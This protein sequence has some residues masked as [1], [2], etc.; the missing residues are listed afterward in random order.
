MAFSDIAQRIR[1]PRGLSA[2]YRSQ[3]QLL[4]FL[5]G[6]LYDD[7]HLTPFDQEYTG[8]SSGEYIRL[9]ERRPSVVSNFA[10]Q[11]VEQTIGLL[12][13]DEQFPIVRC[14]RADNADE[15]DTESEKQIQHLIEA[16]GADQV[17]ARATYLGSVG[18]AAVVVRGLPASHTAPDGQPW[19]E[20]WPG[21]QC[22]P[23]FDPRNPNALTAIATIY[24][25]TGEALKIAGYD[26]LKDD[27]QQTFWMR[28]DLDDRKEM[29][30]KPMRQ[31]RFERIGEDDKGA[32]IKWE[33]QA[34][35]A[36]RFGVVPAVWGRA[37]NAGR[38]IDGPCVFGAAVDTIV[39]LDYQLS[40]IG[41]AY[42]YTADPLLAVKRG[43]LN[44]NSYSPQ[45]S[46]PSQTQT[47]GAGNIV[48]SA[49]N[50]LDIPAGGDAKLLEI[51]GSGL[52]AALDYVRALREYALESIGGM[53]SDAATQKGAQSGRA[54]ELLYQALVIVVK[55]LRIAWGTNALLPLLSLVLRGIQTGELSVPGCVGIDPQSIAM[56]LKWPQWM[57]PTG[58]DFLSTAQGWQLLAGGSAQSPVPILDRETVTRIAATNLGFQDAETLVSEVAAQNESDAQDELQSREQSLK[59]SAQ[60]APPPPSGKNQGAK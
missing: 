10:R 13:A 34:I 1:Y 22:V 28:I 29:R 2:R 16:I 40:Q 21:Y 44:V 24:P 56:R 11:F 25:E 15:Q 57:T 7:A 37:P 41:R 36:H 3:D 6:T 8:F 59:L 14:Y 47:D 33:P 60:Y 4:R 52:T 39:E 23:V 18:S 42:K 54:L 31:D 20:V 38:A 50:V 49:T 35:F 5:D 19:I 51:S 32:V 43:E 27:E 30:Y 9:R 17:L 55:R 53:K 46:K 58:A 12:W 48:K 26:I 45:G